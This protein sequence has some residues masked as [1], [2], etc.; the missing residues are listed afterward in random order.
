M[1]VSSEHPALSGGNSYAFEDLAE[2]DA[3]FAL[4]WPGYVSDSCE[5]SRINWRLTVAELW[6]ES[7]L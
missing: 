5:A 3:V 2:V 7:Q 4:R 6:R 1:G